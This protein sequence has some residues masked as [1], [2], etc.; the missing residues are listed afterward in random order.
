M[1]IEK[2]ATC[3]KV[4][5][6][7]RLSTQLKNL[8]KTIDD[9]SKFGLR[10]K[11]SKGENLRRASNESIDYKVQW[12]SSLEIKE[13]DILGINVTETIDYTKNLV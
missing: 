7:K 2:T 9:L 5:L 1:K 3:P 8:K 4:Q 12:L 10:I 6:T 13:T 11:I